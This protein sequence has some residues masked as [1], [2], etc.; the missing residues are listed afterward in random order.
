MISQADKKRFKA[1]A[2]HLKP[3]VFVAANGLSDSVVREIE[4]ALADHELIKIRIAAGNREKRREMIEA[5]SAA[6]RSEIVQT[7]GSIAV[8]YRAAAEPDPS[9]SNILRTNVF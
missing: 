5:A 2:H 8:L 6:T 1:I 7:I 4:R 3:I 9:L